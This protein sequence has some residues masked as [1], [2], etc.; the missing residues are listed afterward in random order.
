MGAVIGI[1]CLLVAATL[2]KIVMTDDEDG[3]S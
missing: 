3:E 2:I 1:V